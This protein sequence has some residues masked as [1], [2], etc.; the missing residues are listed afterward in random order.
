MGT[1]NM[2]SFAI[3]RVSWVVAVLSVTTLVRLSLPGW[4]WVTLTSGHLLG[5]DRS[6]VRS[7]MEPT[8]IS[9]GGWCQ[10][11]CN[12]WRYDV[13]HCCQNCWVI[14]WISYHLN[15]R[16]SLILSRLGSGKE[17]IALPMRKCPGVG[18]LTSFGS[19][20]S[21]SS[22]LELSKPPIWVVSKVAEAS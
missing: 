1:G 17:L 15:S 16:D 13:D 14:C 4:S 18:A 9:W 8:L 3:G 12:R 20:L 19:S 11:D 6:S 5:G 7:T 10:I 2:A 21:G 22:G